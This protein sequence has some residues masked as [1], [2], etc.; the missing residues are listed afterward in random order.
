MSKFIKL[1]QGSTSEVFVNI[2]QIKLMHFAAQGAT[3]YFGLADGYDCW[4]VN[5]SPDE[6]ME[7]INGSI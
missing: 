1:T 4:T 7:M 5:E 2:N 3:L 6:I